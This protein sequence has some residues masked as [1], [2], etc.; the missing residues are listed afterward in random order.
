M[1]YGQIESIGGNGYCLRVG[2]TIEK[3]YG[4]AHW[5]V[6]YAPLEQCKKQWHE[7]ATMRGQELVILDGIA[8]GLSPNTWGTMRSGVLD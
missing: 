6:I 3:P 8:N 2:E 5:G 1:L 7:N 4:F